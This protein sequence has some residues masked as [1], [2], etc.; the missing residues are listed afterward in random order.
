[1]WD[2]KKNLVLELEVRVS[3]YL[4]LIIIIR[5]NIAINELMGRKAIFNLNLY[6]KKGQFIV[7]YIL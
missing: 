4:I 3:A 7:V 6:Y 2:V 1:V 5:P